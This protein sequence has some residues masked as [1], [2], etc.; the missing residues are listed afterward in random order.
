M[1]IEFLNLNGDSALDPEIK[2]LNLSQDGERKPPSYCLP[3]VEAS[4][5]SIQLKSN[6]DY[7]IRRTNTGLDA[8]AE[9]EGKKMP[10]SDLWLP[11]PAGA[12][13]IPKSPEEAFER[14]VHLSQSPSYSSPWQREQGHSVTLKLGIYWWTPPGWGLFIV[15]AV[16]RND[17]FRIEEGFV[18]TDLWHRDI[19]IVLNP[20][21]EEVRLRKG[22]VIASALPVLAEDFEL[23]PVE[24]ED[25]RKKEII[26]QVNQKRLN[27]SI[28]KKLLKRD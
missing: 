4:R 7:V 12:G 25:A 21:K 26:E 23:V 9:R 22:A 20:L 13:L 10:L 19:P 2:T 17:D 28:Y 8:W 24:H 6:E 16:H 3:W 1:K 27:A 5:Y 18:R 11:L 14:K 15:S